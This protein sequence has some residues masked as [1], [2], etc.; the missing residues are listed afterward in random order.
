MSCTR[1]GID[2]VRRAHGRRQAFTSAGSYLLPMRLA[3]FAVF[4]ALA[5]CCGPMGPTAFVNHVGAQAWFDVA[6]DPQV[7]SAA[8]GRMGRNVSWA[9][10]RGAYSPAENFE[11]VRIANGTAANG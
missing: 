11:Y 8:L 7:A 1:D 4:V 6:W 2:D 10:D 9:D 5:G 3:F